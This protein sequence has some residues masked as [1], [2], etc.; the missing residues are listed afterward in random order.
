MLPTDRD[1]PYSLLMRL[2]QELRDEDA[3]NEFVQRYQPH[4]QSWCCER[5]LQRADTEDVTQIVLEQLLTTMREF[6]YDPTRSFR[7]WLRTVTVRACNRF[8]IKESR[9]AGRKDLSSLRLL[10]EAPARQE[11]ARRLEE[12]FDEELL[13]LAMETVRGSVAP[14]TWEAFR[15]TALLHHNGAEAA[16]QLTMPVMHVYVAR[17]RV[18]MRLRQEVKRLQRLM[19]QRYEN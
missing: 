15:L 5:G 18:Q 9:A 11:L 7:A 10:D 3:W 2:S 16:R 1:T 12:A 6:R 8:V 13:E 14:H 19:D 17:Q 4:I